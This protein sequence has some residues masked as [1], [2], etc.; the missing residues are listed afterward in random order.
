MRRMNNTFIV[1]KSMLRIRG[2]KAACKGAD[3]GQAAVIGRVMKS[4]VVGKSAPEF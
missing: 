3:W 4:V 1:S 2:R